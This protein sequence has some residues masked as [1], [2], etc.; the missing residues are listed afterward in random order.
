M[1]QSRAAVFVILVLVLAT[2]CSS[3]KKSEAQDRT[4]WDP[5]AVAQ[6]QSLQGQIAKQLPGQCTKFSVLPAK[7]E[8]EGIRRLRDKIIPTAVA[9]CNILGEDEE[10]AQFPDAKTRDKWVEERANLF[11]FQAKHNKLRYPGI[12]W[13]TGD[14]WSMVVDT[15]G[16]GRRIARDMGAT[17]RGTPCPGE[18]LDW[19]PDSVATAQ[20]LAD[21]MAA[22]GLGCKD[23]GV[24]DL[25][26]ARQDAL[27]V[28]IG[29]PGAYGVCTLDRTSERELLLAVTDSKSVN[30]QTLVDESAKRN[31]ALQPASAIVV[32]PD[33][34]MM[35]QRAEVATQIAPIVG[36]TVRLCAK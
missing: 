31:C 36:G 8:L 2:S 21:K 30:L 14:A 1:R 29:L 20:G 22:A 9:K 35:T 4:A 11:C 15:E 26:T 27:L 13:V 24:S 18:L 12:H 5:A 16:V 23:F 10:I 32:G 7:G 17:Y 3:S 34:E 6:L 28:K 25:D 33:W 19:D